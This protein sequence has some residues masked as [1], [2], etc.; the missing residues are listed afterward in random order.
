MTNPKLEVPAGLPSRVCRSHPI[1]LRYNGRSVSAYRGDTVASALL[2]SGV[3]VFSRS[4]KYH[5]PRG[6]LCVTGR[7]PNCLMQ[8]EG[9]PNVRA[10]TTPAWDGQRVRHQN[11]Y[12]SPE[13]DLLA[14]AD[15]FGWLMPVGFYY[16]TFTHPAVWHRVEPLI[17][18]VAGLGEVSSRS[19]DPASSQPRYEHV[20]LH[21][22]V[23]VVGGGPSGM[24]AALEA[25]EAGRSVVLVDD[26]PELGGHLLELAPPGEPGSATGIQ[27]HTQGLIAS[28]EQHPNVRVFTD[29]H[30]FGFY[31][32]RLLG[33][34]QRELH[35]PSEGGIASMTNRLIHLR[36]DQVVLATG[37]Y[38]T[39]LPFPNND[40]VGVMLSSGVARLISRYQVQP[41]QRAVVVSDNPNDNGANELLQSAGIEVVGV[42]SPS[43]LR[44][45]T[46]RRQ[47]T[48]VR[49]AIERLACD[50]VVV[51]GPRAADLGLIGQAGGTVAWD[52]RAG[53]FVPGRLPPGVTVVG[54]AAGDGLNARNG[55]IPPG[56]D[57]A[58]RSFVCYCED[59]T[60]KDVNHAIAEGFDHIQTLK[61][62]STITMGPCQGRMC[63]L[64][65]IGL[66]AE[67]TGKS[68]AETGTTTARPP[69]RSVSLGALAGAA[70]HPIRRTPM[71]ARHEFARLHVDEYGPVETAAPLLIAPRR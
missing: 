63:Q 34:E 52:E 61:R 55:G 20:H 32:G 51:C 65:S 12:P 24:Q 37:T 11:A 2:R 26:Q 22:E 39:P 31:E 58:K 16:K 25:A 8:V 36:A 50:L 43:Q 35:M 71:H 40:R 19:K 15:Y 67:R 59:V 1:T 6:L 44:G 48:G 23:A 60:V 18:R 9:V 53:A 28:L 38:E 7:C 33:I 13:F 30:C 46:G 64:A 54:S 68:V 5:R 57:G 14:A 27:T 70:H 21:T 49:T 66:C 4:F 45:V 17:R 62:Y 47:V 42:V 3:R 69:L 29:A 10:C 56:G 41:G